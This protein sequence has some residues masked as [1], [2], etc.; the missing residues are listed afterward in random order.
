MKAKWIIIGLLVLAAGVG[1]YFLF[2][3]KKKP[4]KKTGTD[5]PKKEDE[6]KGAPGGV[7]TAPINNF[8]TSGDE[9]RIQPNGGQGLQVPL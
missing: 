5:A 8:G 3:N 9:L 7:N 4:T 6:K 2:F 1:T